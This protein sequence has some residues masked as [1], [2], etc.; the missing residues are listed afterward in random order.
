MLGSGND[1]LAG[2]LFSG[3][4][5]SCLAL[6]IASEQHEIAC[7]LTVFSKNPESFMFH[8]A[9]IEVT[10]LQAKA[11]GITQLTVKTAGEKEKELEDLKALIEMAYKKFGIKA[12]VSGA[13]ASRYQA[14]RIEETCKK[15]GLSYI[16]PLWGMDQ[17]DILKA[18]LEKKFEVIITA[19]AAYPLDE[20]WLGRRI[21]AKAID[22]LE[23]MREKFRI[24]PAGEGGEF[25]TLVLDAPMFKSRI[26]IVESEKY[27]KNN[28]GILRIKKALLVKK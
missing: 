4:K 3:G 20:S 13:I 28:A 27:Y 24:N 12:I 8:T 22:E 5:D 9:N 16:N 7:M 6:H 14:T 18:V 25:E 1:M 21:D 15:L 11:M 26:K 23:E 19:I 10:R 17:L 2:V